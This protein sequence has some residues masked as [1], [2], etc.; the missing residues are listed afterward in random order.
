M[1]FV[2]VLIGFQ[3]TQ[4]HCILWQFA[5]EV[6]TGIPCEMFPK[7]IICKTTGR[8]EADHLLGWIHKW[9]R[10][11][12]RRL[13]FKLPYL[14]AKKLFIA[15]SAVTSFPACLWNY[16]Y[17]PPKCDF[18]NTDML[19][20]SPKERMEKAET[21]SVVWTREHGCPLRLHFWKAAITLLQ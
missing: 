16:L 7:L 8:W 17:S 21:D 14:F 10:K 1:G 15:F 11:K 20:N 3:T 6:W 4:R 2:L 9:K 12:E 5:R 18:P 19:N 13:T